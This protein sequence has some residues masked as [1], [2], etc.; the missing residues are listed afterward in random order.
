MSSIRHTSHAARRI[1]RGAWMLAVTAAVQGCGATAKPASPDAAA[2]VTALYRDHFAHE[3]NWEATY[4]RQRALFAP[5]L[6]ALLDADGHAAA[7]NADEVVGLDFDPLT[8]AQDG[9]T[10]FQ[11]AP[12]TLEGRAAVVPVM[13][14]LDTAR[15]EVRIRLARSGDAWRVANIHYPHGDLVSLLHRLDAD[16]QRNP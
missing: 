11:V 13:L 1:A 12:V 16:R 9:M 7:A 6:A 3:Q 14:R 5:E 15:S 10:A 4:R 2:V 8:D